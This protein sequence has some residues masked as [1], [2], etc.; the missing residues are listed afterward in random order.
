MDG[1]GK[2]TQEVLVSGMT[3]AASDGELTLDELRGVV[4]SLQSLD[5]YGPTKGH[6]AIDDL[7]HGISCG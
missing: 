5:G 3:K 2:R 7:S 1:I 6:H 4:A